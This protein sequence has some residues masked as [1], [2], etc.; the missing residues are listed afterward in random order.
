MQKKEDRI[1]FIKQILSNQ[2]IGSQ[3]EL[4][5]MINK[6]GF[7]CTQATLSRDLKKLKAVKSVNIDGLYCIKIPIEEP[8]ESK[9]DFK[10]KFKKVFESVYWIGNSNNMI[11]I[12]TAVAY[13]NPVGTVLD[14]LYFNSILGNIAGDDTVLVILKNGYTFNDFENEIASIDKELLSKIKY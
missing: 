11:V 9:D 8:F 7:V 14:N 5:Q 3:D 12:K 6:E 1:Q 2:V 4:M 13:A 10:R